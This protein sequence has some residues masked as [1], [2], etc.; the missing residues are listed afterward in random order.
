ML[1][2]GEVVGRNV[3]F[4]IRPGVIVEIG[5]RARI[6]QTAQGGIRAIGGRHGESVAVFDAGRILGRSE[7]QEARRAVARDRKRRKSDLPKL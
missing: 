4:E 2:L 7:G 6:V 5:G 3:S 1:D